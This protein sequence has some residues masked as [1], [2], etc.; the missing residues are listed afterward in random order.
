MVKFFCF[1]CKSDGINLDDSCF[2]FVPVIPGVG[3]YTKL[4]GKYV[5]NITN[6]LVPYI[7]TFKRTDMAGW[8][9]LTS[10]ADQV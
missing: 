7:S 10:V 2:I 4:V 3:G 6:Q 9:V 1:F 5:C 8:I